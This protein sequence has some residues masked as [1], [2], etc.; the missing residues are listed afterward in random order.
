MRRDPSESH[1]QRPAPDIEARHMGLY[2]K[3]RTQAR[4]WAVFAYPKK[5]CGEKTPAGVDYAK[6][7]WYPVA[8]G[9]EVKVYSGWVGGDA[10]FFYAESDGGSPV[11]AGDYRT[12]VS[13]YAFDNCWDTGWSTGREV[14]CRRVRPGADVMDYTIS[15]VT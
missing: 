2:F 6:K 10:W 1:G 14:G 12:D 15:L 3:N 4:I 8:P 7:G 13:I 9:Q 5:Q 11:W